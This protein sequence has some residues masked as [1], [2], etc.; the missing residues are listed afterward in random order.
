MI[1][2]VCAMLIEMG[3]DLKSILSFNKDALTRSQ[4]HQMCVFS[5]GDFMYVVKRVQFYTEV[6]STRARIH[7][8]L[9]NKNWIYYLKNNF[10]Y[11][12]IL[13]PTYPS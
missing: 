2:S 11:I 12:F 10:F 13:S 4:M 8:F 9:V 6:R 3:M 7:F 5:C 1:V